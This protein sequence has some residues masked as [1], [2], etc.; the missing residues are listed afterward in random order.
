MALYHVKMYVIQNI[1]N[2]AE[3]SEAVQTREYLTRKLVQHEPLTE[4]NVKPNRLCS[5]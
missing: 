1:Q 4:K 2:N 3:K 5:I